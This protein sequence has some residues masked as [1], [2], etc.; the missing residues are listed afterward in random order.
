M[1]SSAPVLDF[2]SEASA[3][4]AVVTLLRFIGEDPTREG[5]AETPARVVKAWR[6]MTVW[7]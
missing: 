6:E 5:I 1:S 4:N 3:E 7:I 2:V